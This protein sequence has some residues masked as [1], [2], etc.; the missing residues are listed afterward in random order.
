VSHGS[1]VVRR[2]WI[3]VRSYDKLETTINKTNDLALVAAHDGHPKINGSPNIDVPRRAY[4]VSH[5]QAIWVY[6]KVFT[7]DAVGAA[8]VF[9]CPRVWE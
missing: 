8:P 7:Q 4:D 2:L 6:K 1:I 5:I 9:N 3:P